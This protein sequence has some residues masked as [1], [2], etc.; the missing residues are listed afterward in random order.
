MSS[1]LLPPP[2]AAL[3]LC[4]TS[5][6]CYQMLWYQITYLF[7]VLFD[8][9]RLEAGRSFGFVSDSLLNAVES[10]VGGAS[11]PQHLAAAAGTTVSRGR[12]WWR[13]GAGRPESGLTDPTACCRG[14]VV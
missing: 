12:R 6:Q 1:C 3:V 8:L 4:N 5:S 14:P 11:L 10:T 2:P 13:C 7:A 9:G